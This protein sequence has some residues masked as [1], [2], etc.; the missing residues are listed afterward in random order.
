MQDWDRDREAA[1]PEFEARLGAS[2][3]SL[4]PDGYLV[5]E[6][7]AR[8]G[9]VG[10]GGPGGRGAV[11]C[12]G[13][14]PFV[15]FAREGSS[16]LAEAAGNRHL[17]GE[18]QLD[19]GREA[20]LAAMGWEPPSPG[21]AHRCNWSHRWR[22]RVPFAMVAALAVRTLRGVY[23]AVTAAEIRYAR[24]ARDGRAMPDPALGVDGI[25]GSGA[26]GWAAYPTP[27]LH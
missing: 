20:T 13:G 14:V 25:D 6:V 19:P 11:G 12:P 7:H 4:P 16:L 5:L 3:G 26:S 22:G 1:W 2:L 24:F 21:V 10:S 9:H 23:G 15:Q 27:R 18:L 8:A 17:T